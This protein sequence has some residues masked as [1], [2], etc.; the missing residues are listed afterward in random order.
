MTKN[1]YDSNFLKDEE[2]SCVSSDT[3]NNDIMDEIEFE[4][5]SDFAIFRQN[6]RLEYLFV[7]VE[8]M[9]ELPSSFKACLISTASQK[10]SEKIKMHH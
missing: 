7:K 10:K 3:T 5:K 4:V 1:S 2:L 9:E 8:W 6:G